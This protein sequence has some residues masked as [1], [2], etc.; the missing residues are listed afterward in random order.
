MLELKLYFPVVSIHRS[1]IGFLDHTDYPCSLCP[2]LAFSYLGESI[3]FG[4][5]QI[6]AWYWLC[7]FLDV[8]LYYSSS[9]S[10]RGVRTP[11]L[12]A[13]RGFNMGKVLHT[14]RSTEWVLDRITSCQNIAILGQGSWA[15]LDGGKSPC[16]SILKYCGSPALANPS[17]L[18]INVPW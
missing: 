10:Q 15:P 11:S 6:W 2:M 14:V 5:Q 18:F 16:S 17:W 12:T 4:T 7:Y 3:V 13:V 9:L 8:R 1:Q